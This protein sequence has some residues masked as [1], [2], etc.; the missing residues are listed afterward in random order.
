MDL[1]DQIRHWN[2]VIGEVRVFD[3]DAFG[4]RKLIAALVNEYL[5]SGADVAARLVG[6]YSAY[7]IGAM[8]FEF[9][10]LAAPGDPIIPPAF[11]RT[12]GVSYYSALAAPRDFIRVPMT[13]TP[14]IIS[15]DAA[16]YDGNQITFFAMTSGDVGEHAVAFSHTQNST[17]FGG[18]LV[19]TPEPDTQ[20]NDLVWSRTYWAADAVLKQQN[21]QIG[22]QWTLR[23]L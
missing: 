2:F 19:S 10:N 23:F 13:I 1:L 15:S 20:A 22:V 18:A 16:K 9:E 6:G 8:Y 21:H 12:G 17:V 5:Y 11:D 7:K 4:K 3:V 14:T